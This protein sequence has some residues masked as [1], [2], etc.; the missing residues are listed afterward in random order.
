M[1]FAFVVAVLI[2]IGILAGTLWS[3]KFIAT[4]PP[5]EPNLD[6]IKEVDVPYVCAVCGMSLTVTQAQDGDISPPRHCREDMIRA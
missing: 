3:V 6:E 2:G 1:T 5:P 4:G